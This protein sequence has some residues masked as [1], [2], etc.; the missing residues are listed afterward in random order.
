MNGGGLVQAARKT[1][2]RVPESARMGWRHRIVASWHKSF[3]AVIETGDLIAAAKTALPHGQF[4][5]MVRRELPFSPN[6]ARRLM[7]IAA[8]PRFRNTANQS[9]LPNSWGTLYELTKLDGPTFTTKLADGTIR[10]D[11]MR[12]DILRLRAVSRSTRSTRAPAK[13]LRLRDGTEV[14]RIAFGELRG[15]IAVASAELKLLQALAAYGIPSSPLS[16]IGEVISDTDLRAAYEA[17]HSAE[18]EPS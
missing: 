11:M 8:D 7:T 1:D 12:K 3:E 9:R 15:L 14:A 18:S 6:T 17:A 5:I 2:D 4:Q 10:P 16:T 13:V